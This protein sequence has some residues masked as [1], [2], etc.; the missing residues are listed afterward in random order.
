M[1]ELGSIVTDM[2]VP[3][4]LTLISYHNVIFSLKQKWIFPFGGASSLP[5]CGVW[6]EF[7]YPSK[8]SWRQYI[9]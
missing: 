9:K 2:N 7:L 6:H 8:L 1:T 5:Y 4:Q 3:E